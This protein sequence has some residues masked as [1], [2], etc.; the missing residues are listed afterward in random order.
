M[1]QSENVILIRYGEI[2]LKGKNIS[3]FENLLYSNIKYALKGIACKL[4]RL[5]SRYAVS[6]YASDAEEEICVRVSRV[7]G[8]HSLSVARK[9]E[10]ARQSIIDTVMKISPKSGAFRV[11][12]KRADKKFPV[13]SQ[14]FSAEIGGLLS[15]EYPEL[16]VNLHEYDFEVNVDI[17]ENGYTFVFTDKI[18][19][20]GGMP[21]GSAGGGALMLSGGIDSPVAGYMMAKRGLKL[22][23][24]HF[25]SF[26]YTGNDA[27]EKVKKLARIL[28]DYCGSICMIVV[29]FT[30]IQEEIHAKCDASFMITVM[31]RFMMRIA[32]KIADIEGC[33]AIVTGESLGQVASQTLQSITVTTA[34]STLPVFRP[35]IGMDKEEI[36]EKAR[37][38]GTFETSILPYDDCCTVFLP[39]NPQTRP[40][41][42]RAEYQERELAVDALVEEALNNLEYIHINPHSES[43]QTH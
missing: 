20:P 41:L 18:A 21:V 25:H 8:I 27:K 34:V 35:L 39:E 7:F 38:I 26:P 42:E 1:S 31:R 24:V 2:Y 10:S 4:E 16:S 17:R 33:G 28:A 23:A 43:G 11:N 22:C 19:G 12:V 9:I 6:D 32:C 30:K 13:H 40:R 36:I 29:P 3:F 14:P 5:R 15:R 37:K